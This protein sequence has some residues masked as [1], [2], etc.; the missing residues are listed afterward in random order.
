M[1]HAERLLVVQKLD[2]LESRLNHI[3]TR[4]IT[5]LERMEIRIMATLDDIDSALTDAIAQAQTDISRTAALTAQA[6][7]LIMAMQ[8]GA[9][10]VHADAIVAK[11]KAVSGTLTS[12]VKAA[13][14][15]LD[16]LMNPVPV[17]PPS[18]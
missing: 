17:P 1:D 9:D 6:V 13:L 12:T 8:A 5:H 14:D 16:A 7:T 15:P 2:H 4:I 10:P 11:I 18:Q 3:E